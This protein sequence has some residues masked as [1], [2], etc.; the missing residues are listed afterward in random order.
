MKFTTNRANT[1][2]RYDSAGLSID[3]RK[4]LREY[5]NDVFKMLLDALR[6]SR[7]YSDG[8]LSDTSS[9]EN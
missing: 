5:S 8:S 3:E 7:T 9:N 1:T 4:I 2:C 6:N